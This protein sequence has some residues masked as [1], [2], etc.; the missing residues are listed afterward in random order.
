MSG[1]DPFNYLQVL[2]V[3]DLTNF[4]VIFV[5]VVVCAAM[6]VSIVFG[7]RIKMASEIGGAILNL[8]QFS[9][10]GD[11]V[12]LDITKVMAVVTCI[13]LFEALCV[14]LCMVVWWY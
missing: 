12:G 10:L 13:D 3:P 14:L 1:S 8:L 9:L 6:A 7:P 11:G 5:I 4:L 2:A